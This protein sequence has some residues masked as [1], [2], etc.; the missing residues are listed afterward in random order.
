MTPEFPLESLLPTPALDEQCLKAVRFFDNLAKEEKLD[1]ALFKVI[2]PYIYPGNTISDF[3]GPPTTYNE[4]ALRVAPAIY[5]ALKKAG[6]EFQPQVHY[7]IPEIP[8]TFFKA[9][10]AEKAETLRVF[11][12]SL[13]EYLEAD[14]ILDTHKI[15]EQRREWKPVFKEQF[16][17]EDS[18]GRPL[19][20]RIDRNKIRSNSIQGAAGALEIIKDEMKRTICFKPLAKIYT[21]MEAITK[22]LSDSGDPRL[23]PAATITT[24]ERLGCV[25]KLDQIFLSALEILAKYK[26]E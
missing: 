17:K 8:E 13:K 15:H 20:E 5:T 9:V 12:Q 16:G 1:I 10:D 18:L 25:K 19:C 4:S 22:K 24:A 14:I 11:C 3:Q 23:L 2:W 26:S 7:Q 21:S 6:V